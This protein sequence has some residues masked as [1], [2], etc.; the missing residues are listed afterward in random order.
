M[1]CLQKAHIRYV[2]QQQLYAP[3]ELVFCSIMISV[4]SRPKFHQYDIIV[5]PVNNYTHTPSEHAQP[6]FLD[7]Y[8]TWFRVKG[9]HQKRIQPYTWP[10]NT[11]FWTYFVDIECYLL[12]TFGGHMY[13]LY[14]FMLVLLLLTSNDSGDIVP[15][16]DIVLYYPKDQLGHKY[17]ADSGIE[18][19]HCR[20]SGI[21]VPYKY[22]SLKHY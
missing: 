6:W 17:L 8:H 9:L 16:G 2:S 12:D 3:T 4:E 7:L 18:F 10:E 21:K 14:C 15:K 11:S 13:C 1:Q 20:N 5:P 19:E 22:R